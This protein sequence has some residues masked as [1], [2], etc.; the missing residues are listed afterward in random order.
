M[1]MV[2]SW[3]EQGLINSE[4]AVQRAG[5]KTWTKLSQAVDLRAWGN[6]AAAPEEGGARRPRRPLRARGPGPRNATRPQATGRPWRST[7]GPRSRACCCSSAPERAVFLYFHPQDVVSPLDR[8]PF[9]PVALGLLA[10]ALALLPGWDWSRKL[11]RVAALVVAI[12]AF[13]LLGILFAQGVRGSALLAV[14]GIVVFFFALFA[15]LSEPAPHWAKAALGLVAVLG[16]GVLAGY[17]GYAPETDAQRQIREATTRER[18]FSDPSLA[19]QLDLPEGW[20]RPQEGRRDGRHSPR[21]EGDLRPRPPA[22]LR[23]PGHGIFARGRDLARRMARPGHG[24][25]A[26]GPG[27]RRRR[28]AG[29]RSRWA[30]S[31]GGGPALPRTP[32][33]RPTARRPRRGATDG[34]TTRSWPGRPKRRERRPSTR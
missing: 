3:Y 14:L 29:P 21:R 8:A 20:A 28:R 10:C 30:P 12:L 26:Q 32:R 33:A 15:F 34:C 6:L 16:G 18:R 19:V 27:H 23:L 9:W 5:S 31:P 1:V 22:G 4:S 11:V 13:P 24:G 2:R 25:E 17:F 7:G